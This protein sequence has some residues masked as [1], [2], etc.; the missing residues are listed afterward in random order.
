MLGLK[1]I[2]II[3]PIFIVMW[4]QAV[5]FHHRKYFIDMECPEGNV[6]LLFLNGKLG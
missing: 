2:K 5:L 6:N 4:I 1:N 3:K